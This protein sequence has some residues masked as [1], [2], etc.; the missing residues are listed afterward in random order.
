MIPGFCA[1][2]EKH[3]GHVRIT[4]LCS[5]CVEGNSFFNIFLYLLKVLIKIMQTNTVVFEFTKCSKHIIFSCLFSFINF[6][7]ILK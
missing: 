2:T 7:D 6:S 1:S 4:H 3:Q 5:I